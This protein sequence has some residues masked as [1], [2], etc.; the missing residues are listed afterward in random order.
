[1]ERLPNIAAVF[2]DSEIPENVEIM[3][4]LEDI[5]DELW[6]EICMITEI[7]E[8]SRVGGGMQPT[9]SARPACLCVCVLACASSPA[10]MWAFPCSV[11]GMCRFT[12]RRKTGTLPGA[13]MCGVG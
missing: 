8:N 7:K 5:D 12:A 6:P 1:M 4:K 11:V 13:G 3:G 10:F 9:Q 2:F